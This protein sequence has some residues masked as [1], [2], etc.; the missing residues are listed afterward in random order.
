MINNR[1]NEIELEVNIMN[2]VVRIRILS[3]D[4]STKEITSRAE[5][6]AKKMLKINSE[7]VRME[8]A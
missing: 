1:P 6:L 2:K 4:E 5:K 8:V 3:N 7:S